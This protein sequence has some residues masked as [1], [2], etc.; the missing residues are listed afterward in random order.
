MAIVNQPLARTFSQVIKTWDAATY[1]LHDKPDWENFPPTTYTN[2]CS[3]DDVSGSVVTA[4]GRWRLISGKLLCIWSAITKEKGIGRLR[5]FISLNVRVKVLDPTS[6]VR[7]SMYLRW[8]AHSTKT[9]NQRRCKW[10][11]A[12]APKPIAQRTGTVHAI[13]KIR[14]SCPVIICMAQSS[15][16]CQTPN[17]TCLPNGQVYNDQ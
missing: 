8:I 4:N 12:V 15:S 7:L 13:L 17:I 16:T 2:F 10:T 9:N 5:G 14:I 1:L 11:E 3:L 6:S